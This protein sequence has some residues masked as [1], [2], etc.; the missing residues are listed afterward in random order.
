MFKTIVIGCGAMGLR[1]IQAVSRVKDAV[2]CG[3]CDLS[4]GAL[5]KAREQGVPKE[6]CFTD[7]RRM[8]ETVRPDC[9]VIAT[10]APSHAPLSLLALEY[11]VR[12][13]LVEKP[14]CTSLAQVEKLSASVKAHEA[15][16]AVNHG[17]RFDS[18]Y[19]RVRELLNDTGLGP[20]G[21]IVVAG[22]NMGVAMNAS[23]QFELFRVLTGD[24]PRMVTAWFANTSIPNPRGAEF[25]DAAGQLRLV[26]GKGQRLYIEIGPD[27]GHGLNMIIQCKYGHVVIDYLAG[28]AIL[29]KRKSDQRDWPTT[30]YGLPCTREAIVLPKPDATATAAKVLAAL[31]SGADYPDATVGEQVIRTLVAAHVSN[32][33][34]HRAV[35][36]NCDLPKDR[37]FP[38]A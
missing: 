28:E 12:Y 34:E 33:N 23:H 26:N 18:H 10:T 37:I 16:L 25:I 13:L 21:S 38:W 19:S 4:E 8:L 24:F 6:L 31:L 32:E 36:I 2:L 29:T 35:D 14:F 7:V 17:M 15:K 1:H 5:L 11:G 20:V 3:V 27:Q 22:G 30:R 9:A